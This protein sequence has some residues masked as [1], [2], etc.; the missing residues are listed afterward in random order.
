MS[1]KKLK[2]IKFRVHPDSTSAP[3]SPQHSPPP[4]PPK[5]LSQPPSPTL[6]SMHDYDNTGVCDDLFD[7][8]KSLEIEENSKSSYDKYLAPPSKAER[9]YHPIES[10]SK[11]ALTAL[12]TIKSYRTNVPEFGVKGDE[13]L[14][15]MSDSEIVKYLEDVRSGK[16]S[17]I[18]ND[19]VRSVFFTGTQQIEVMAPSL[20]LDLRGYSAALSQNP[21]IDMCLRCATSEINGAMGD[22]LPWYYLLPISMASIGANVHLTN[23]METKNYEKFNR[24][25]KNNFNGSRS[26]SQPHLQQER[27]STNPNSREIGVGQN[28]FDEIIS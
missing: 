24:P 1:S 21:Q 2:K 17:L 9:T 23:K 12:R 10:R 3:N 28:D 11:E 20:G 7:E 5:S 25:I 4:S 16:Q 18:T 14:D 19:A 6:D 22:V 26:T 8:I 27:T 15:L 13:E